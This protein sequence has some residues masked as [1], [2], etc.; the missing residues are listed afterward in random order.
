MPLVIM[1]DVELEPLDWLWPGRLL[2]GK[3]NLIVGDG[4]IGKSTLTIDLAARLSRGLPLPDGTQH[5]P[6]GTLLVMPEDG[7]GDTIRPRLEN[8]GADL[9]RIGL[10]QTLTDPEDGLEMMPTIPDHITNLEDAIDAL[11][12][13]LLVIDP[14]LGCMGDGVNEYRDKEVRRAMAPLI[15]MCERKDVALVCLLHVTKAVSGNAKHRGNASVAFMNLSRSTLYAAADPDIPGCFVLAQSKTNLGPL[16]PSLRYRLEG[17]PNGHARVGWEGVSAHT[18]DSLDAQGGNTE[19]RSELH[20]A[21]EFLRE[22]L[23]DGP[24][25]YSGIIKL[26]RGAGIAE[27]TLKRAK[28]TLRVESKKARTQDG[29]WTWQLPPDRPEPPPPKAAEGGQIPVSELLEPLAPLELFK[30][31]Q[32]ECQEGQER[33]GGQESRDKK[34]APFASRIPVAASSGRGF[35]CAICGR[36][37][38]AVEGKPLVCRYCRES[39]VLATA[40]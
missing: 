7:A 27:R 1:R 34:A 12:A 40:D 3:Y 10:I 8:A 21:E 11:G 5:A 9:S 31:Y 24:L 13:R 17:C 6:C 23:A 37:M 38:M 35:S 19:E 16:A 30:E 15:S 32:E 4:G 14:L 28:A 22:V 39:G 33:Q 25:L 18:A 36:P 29:Q 20:D 2:F 26:A